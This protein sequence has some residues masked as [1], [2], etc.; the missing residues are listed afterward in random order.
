MSPSFSTVSRPLWKEWHPALAVRVAALALLALSLFGCGPSFHEL[1][2]TQPVSMA[3]MTDAT[4]S[5][6]AGRV[7]L[8]DNVLGSGMVDESALAVELGITNAGRE[9]YSLSAAS[10]SCWMEL[11]PDAPGETLS[12]TPAGGGE[13]PFPK[14]LSLEDQ[15]LGSTTIPPGETRRYW[16]VFRG[17]KY[18]GSEVP[19]KISLLMPDA[20]G[21]RIRVV[22]A[23]P[24]NGR[25]RWE[26][27]PKRTG[28]M[29][30]IQNTTLLASGLTMTGIAGNLSLVGRAGPILWDVGLSARML[31]QQRGGLESPTSSFTGTGI[32]AHVFLPAVTWGSWQ[33]RR[34]F[35]F[36][37]GGEAQF[38]VAIQPP[39]RSGE[40]AEVPNTYGTL[41]AEGG[42]EL[43]V[44]S[45]HH[46]S[47]P[48]PI[49]YTG[50]ALPRWSI[51]LGYTHMFVGGLNSGGYTTTF[52]LAW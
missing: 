45:R 14:G 18:A 15:Q 47:S 48:F 52:R 24:A 33:D 9:P 8:T 43:S 32:N 6:E 10:I 30:G 34:Q 31:V 23:D 27:A 17:Y 49:S 1:R 36:Y 20:R 28:Y 44:G 50:P 35:G 19:R 25:L 21:R 16:V 7:F 2:L 37:A 22:I 29:Y 42:L 4:V 13:G 3:P 38:L 40:M 12:L 39:P 5:V 11:S 26:I 41:A 46:P 51:R